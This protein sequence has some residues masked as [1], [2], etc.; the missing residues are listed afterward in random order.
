MI[1]TSSPVH[2]KTHRSRRAGAGSPTWLLFT[3]LPNCCDPHRPRSAGGQAGVQFGDR[4]VGDQHVEAVGNENVLVRG[5]RFRGN[6]NRRAGWLGRGH[7]PTY[8]ER[9]EPHR[10]HYCPCSM[11]AKARV[12]GDSLAQTATRAT[13]PKPGLTGHTRTESNVMSLRG[14]P[15]STCPIPPGLFPFSGHVQAATL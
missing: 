3:F 11:P 5:V 15:M 8:R 13:P 14:N 10:H 6:R 4:V 2:C 9:G 12:I 7:Q 1:W